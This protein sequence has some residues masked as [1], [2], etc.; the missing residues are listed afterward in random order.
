MADDTKTELDGSA[1]LERW[2]RPALPF[3]V[4]GA[5]LTLGVIRGPG[6]GV[7]GLAAGILVLAIS[8]LWGSLRVLVGEA[9]LTLDAA[10]AIGAAMQED[11]QKRAILRALKDLEIE[12]GLGKIT[13]EDFRELSGRYRADAKRILRD[14]DERM[15]PA[16]KKAEELVA[17]HL[18][19]T[20]LADAPAPRKKR[21]KRARLEE[22]ASGPRSSREAHTPA[23]SP[24]AKQSSSPPPAGARTCASCELS[25]DVDAVFCKKCGARLQADASE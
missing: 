24:V 18:A 20:D 7:L 10:V 12:H 21:S 3:L 13:D 1:L 9:P 8:S 23:E 2:G 25:N 11:E 5:A 17:S 4:L 15:E 16:R 22:E 6:A 14:I 19:G